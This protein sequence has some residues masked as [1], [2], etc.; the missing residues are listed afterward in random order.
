MEGDIREEEEEMR[1]VAIAYFIWLVAT[2]IFLIFNFMEKGQKQGNKC[3]LNKE[4]HGKR[5]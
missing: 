3:P 5:S 2:V 1:V 4:H